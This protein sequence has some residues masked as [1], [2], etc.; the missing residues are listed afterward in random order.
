MPTMRRLRLS[1][2]TADAA[3]PILGAGA[4]AIAAAPAILEQIGRS[5]PQL[6]GF[7]AE[8]VIAD[9]RSTID[10]YAT[11]SGTAIPLLSLQGGDRTAAE[12]RLQ[13]R[14]DQ[15][16]S[17]AATTSDPQR[18]AQLEAA[19]NYP[20]PDSVF[21]VGQEPVLTQGGSRARRGAT[22]APPLT[23]PQAGLAGAAVSRSWLLPA[24]LALL[25]FVV[26]LGLLGWLQRDR[27]VAWLGHDAQPDM[28]ALQP[29]IDYGL[30]QVA[31]LE[32][33]RQRA[34]AL[35]DQVKALRQEFETKKA[36]CPV[37]PPEPTPPPPQPTPP[38]E[39]KAEVPPPAP[40][41]K[42]EPPKKVE[43]QPKPAQPKPVE[44]KP[45]PPQVA[46]VTP[47]PPAPKQSCEQA[48]QARK[49]W[50]APEVVFVIDASG[51]MREDAG[52]ETRLEAAK[53]SVAVIADNL[54]ADVDTAL[55]K[56]TNCNAIDNDYFLDRAALKQKVNAL[57]PEGG[58]PLARSIERAANILSK[59][60][61]TV[62]VVV[63]DG[64]DSCGRKDPC[65][66]AA[67]AK[68]SHPNLTINVVDVSGDGGATCIARNGGGQV[69]PARTPSEIKSAMQQA[70]Y[71]HTLPSACKGTP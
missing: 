42:P 22:A 64:E 65:A 52:N 16:R 70:T 59:K 18:K 60:K 6:A 8:P 55:V 29:A 2:T 46:T 30:D 20:S 39:K 67:A 62:M 66:V 48:I 36:A 54:P 53:Q 40:K 21:V 38:P 43:A 7:L 17:L 41:P 31:A 12:E 45:A 44:P 24:L 57:Q 3:D 51:S 49:P 33:E 26:L 27:L 71:P 47:P 58:T 56:F 4:R 61:E 13:F 14:L 34:A 37:P 19:A 1:R 11:I 23:A 69:L 63:T 32:A 9:D 10:W 68:A 28:A 35:R 5:V 25:L 15:L 50:D